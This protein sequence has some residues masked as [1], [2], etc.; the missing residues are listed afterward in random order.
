MENDFSLALLRY[1]SDVSIYHLSNEVRVG[2]DSQIHVC[3]HRLRRQLCR[4]I[5]DVGHSVRVPAPTA[6]VQIYCCHQQRIVPVLPVVGGDVEGHIFKV[7]IV[8]FFVFIVVLYVLHRGNNHCT[9]YRYHDTISVAHCH[10]HTHLHI[11]VDAIGNADFRIAR[12]V[13][14]CKQF[15]FSINQADFPYIPAAHIGWYHRG[16]FDYIFVCLIQ[17]RLRRSSPHLIYQCGS[18][19]VRHRNLSVAIAYH[20]KG[21]LDFFARLQIGC[22]LF[23]ALVG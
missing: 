18:R 16:S 23:G 9:V 19:R 21:N 4:Y 2:F 6:L 14:D 13:G 3:K 10:S 20:Y 11:V 17:H 22:H 7:T 1:Q 12:S 8:S 15:P 5:L